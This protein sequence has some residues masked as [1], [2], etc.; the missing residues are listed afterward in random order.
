MNR[1]EQSTQSMTP[2]SA[3]S[4][5]IPHPVDGFDPKFDRRKG[6]DFRRSQTAYRAHSS[7]TSACEIKKSLNLAAMTILGVIRHN[8]HALS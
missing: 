3:S 2:R 7:V 5:D 8:M 6:V 1:P 4:L